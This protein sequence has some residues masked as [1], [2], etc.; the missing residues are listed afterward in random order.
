[1]AILATDK[2][3]ERHM[4]VCAT[5]G[6]SLSADDLAHGAKHEGG[7]HLPSAGCYVH[8]G[9][10]GDQCPYTGVGCKPFPAH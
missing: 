10:S 2:R 6:R 4:L 1:M 8:S 3:K 9:F 5:C 7:V